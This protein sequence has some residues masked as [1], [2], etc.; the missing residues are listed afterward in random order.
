M[1]EPGYNYRL[2][3]MH[4]ALGRSQLDKLPTFAA[5]R[6]ELV[7]LYR[8]QLRG[9]EPLVSVPPD[10]PGQSPVHHLMSVAVDFDRVGKSRRQVMLEL[11]E[12]GV[13]TQVHYI[14]VHRQPY[15][16][17]LDPDL[18][19][20]GA[21]AYYAATLSLPLFPAMSDDDVAHVVDALAHCVRSV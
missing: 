21:D 18:S 19:L 6:Q 2:S 12:R 17:A 8:E 1:P 14:P 9:L 20:P 3:D 15:Y 7:R 10:P 16:R 11:K 13:G 4:A 5:R